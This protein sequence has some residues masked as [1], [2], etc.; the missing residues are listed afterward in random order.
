M[1]IIEVLLTLVRRPRRSHEVY[2]PVMSPPRLSPIFTRPASKIDQNW[3]GNVELGTTSDEEEEE[4]E[5][6]AAAAVAAAAAAA[7]DLTNFNGARAKKKEE[8]G[9]KKKKSVRVG[10]KKK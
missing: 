1:S 4:E 6:D 3:S 7:A 2:S 5:E 8:G 10:K 9:G